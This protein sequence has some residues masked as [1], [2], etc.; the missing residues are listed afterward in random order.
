MQF[1]HLELSAIVKAAQGMIAADGRVDDSETRILALEITKFGVQ[2]DQLKSMIELAT[3][4]EPSLMLAVLGAMNDS[5]K[6]YV[7]GFLASIMVIDGDI[8]D[9]EMKFWQMTSTYI[10]CPRMSLEEALKYWSNN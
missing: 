10:G 3:A 6:R 9:A 8:D 7:C 5:Q 4:M 2:P 1:S